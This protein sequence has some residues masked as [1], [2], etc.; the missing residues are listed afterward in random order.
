[1]ERHSK[2]DSNNTDIISLCFFYKFRRYRVPPRNA[3]AKS[4]RAAKEPDDC[5]S[6]VSPFFPIGRVPALLAL[7]SLANAIDNDRK[8]VVVVRVP[9]LNPRPIAHKSKHLLEY[10]RYLIIGVSAI[11]SNNQIFDSFIDFF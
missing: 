5:L 6:A 1:M 4:G 9:D 10:F 3:L 7:H 8:W 2:V 11:E